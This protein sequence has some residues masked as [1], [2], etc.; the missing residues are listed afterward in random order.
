MDFIVPAIAVIALIVL[1]FFRYYFEV[2]KPKNEKRRAMAQLAPNDD[3]GREIKDLYELYSGAD[4]PDKA[5]I[6]LELTEMAKTH[7]LALRE[8]QL[9]L[10]S[11]IRVK[12]HN[13][14]QNMAAWLKAPL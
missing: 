14:R 7:D 3:I 6:L 13:Y 2:Y 5:V 10:D 9:Q 11:E 4:H 8:P 1:F 12:C